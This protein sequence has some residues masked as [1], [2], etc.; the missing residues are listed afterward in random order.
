M[1]IKKT[2]IIAEAGVNHDGKL[3]K[4]FKLA[5]TAKKIKADFIKFQAFDPNLLCTVNASKA[6]YQKK[7]LFKKVN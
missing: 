5:E 2:I 4:A 7:I 3:N 1:N 6:E